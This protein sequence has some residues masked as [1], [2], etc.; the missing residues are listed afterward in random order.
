[1]VRRRLRVRA[2]EREKDEADERMDGFLDHGRRRAPRR[3]AGRRA[4]PL[5]EALV[6]ARARATSGDWSGAGGASLVGLYAHC[7][8]ALYGVR[9]AE[10]DDRG[11]FVGAARSAATIVREHFGGDCDAAA[12]FVRWT[13]IRERGREEWAAREGKD[14]GRMGFRLQFSARLV[15]DFKVD[16]TRRR[17]RR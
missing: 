2:P 15:T 17:R 14:R 1:M 3:S 13:W 12:A 8:E 7:H 5:E 16:A 6:D 11:Q 10:L 4:T 9:P